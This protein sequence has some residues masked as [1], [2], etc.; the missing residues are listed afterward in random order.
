MSIDPFEPRL[1]NSGSSLDPPLLLS[2][3]DQVLTFAEWCALNRISK[4]TGR[5]ILKAPGGPV[6]THL[7]EKKIG[8]TIGNNR[9]WQ[10]TRARERT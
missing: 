6:V 4:R 9:R 2:H 1:R 7:T 8:V 10:A 3:D 5:R